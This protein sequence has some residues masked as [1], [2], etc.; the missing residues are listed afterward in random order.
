MAEMHLLLANLFTRFEIE[1]GPNSDDNMVW[2]DRA[3][4]HPK[5]N[6]RVKVKPKT[7]VKMNGNGVVE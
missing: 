3:I 7:Q 5:G 4:V 2:L 1:L 6:L